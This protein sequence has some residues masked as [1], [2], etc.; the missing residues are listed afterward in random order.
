M[1]THKV[2]LFCIPFAG[3]HAAYF[4]SWKAHLPPWVELIPV[5]LAGRGKRFGESG[6][7][8]MT[9]AVDDVYSQI[10]AAVRDGVSY[11]VFGHSLGSM[12]TYEVSHK[13]KE[14]NVKQPLHLFV[15]AKNAPHTYSSA[16]NK[17]I[18]Q[19]SDR[20]FIQEIIGL[21]GT[22]TEL[23]EHK[24]LLNL[25]IPVI[26][27]DY[28]IAETYEHVP[29]AEKLD[30]GISV[31]YGIDDTYSDDEISAWQEQ[32]ELR[33]RFYAFDGGHFYLNDH[34][35]KITKLIVRTLEQELVVHTV[36]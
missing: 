20:E 27:K 26:R 22:S 14:M 31:L 16:K 35:P 19:L 24:E 21:G 25:F 2:Q 9:E 23:M 13:L 28:K 33:C 1:S 29:R 36:S 7:E 12:I 18:H 3:G 11:A 17:F 10:C 30:I 34:L 4:N 5:E 8:S 32:T 6:Y 15:S